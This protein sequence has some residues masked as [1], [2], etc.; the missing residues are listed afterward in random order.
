MTSFV[1]KPKKGDHQYAANLY[2]AKEYA[3]KYFKP[4][5]KNLGLVW[6]HLYTAPV[7]ITS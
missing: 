4:K 7:V 5:K 1:N 3:V 6:V 2:D